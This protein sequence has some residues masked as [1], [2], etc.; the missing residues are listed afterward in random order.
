MTHKEMTLKDA[1]KLLLEYYKCHVSPYNINYDG[2][3][4]VNGLFNTFAT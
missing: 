3:D 4:G 2:N 1:N